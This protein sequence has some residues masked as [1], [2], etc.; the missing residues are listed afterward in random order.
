MFI[1]LNE[2]VSEFSDMVKVFVVSLLAYAR[3]Y[4]DKGIMLFKI[5]GCIKIYAYL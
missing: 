3:S 5:E 2:F 1:I 4:I